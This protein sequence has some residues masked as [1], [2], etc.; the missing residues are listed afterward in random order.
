MTPKI[1]IFNDE[2]DKLLEEIADLEIEL[3]ELMSEETGIESELKHQNE[4]KKLLQEILNEK[5]SS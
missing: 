1:E 2:K 4:Q 5:K 3:M